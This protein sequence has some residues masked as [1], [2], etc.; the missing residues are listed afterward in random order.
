MKSFLVLRLGASQIDVYVGKQSTSVQMSQIDTAASDGPWCI[1]QRVVYADK[2]S[3]HVSYIDV[4][5]TT[6]THETFAGLSQVCTGA[7][8]N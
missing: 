1:L 6:R 2:A 7:D 5:D 3:T 8:Q 4:A